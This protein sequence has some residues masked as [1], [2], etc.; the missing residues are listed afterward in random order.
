MLRWTLNTVQTQAS[1]LVCTCT[2][3]TFTEPYSGLPRTG[4]ADFPVARWSGGNHNLHRVNRRADSLLPL[5]GRS[6][7]HPFDIL[8]K[9]DADFT[10]VRIP[11][12]RA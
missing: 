8:Q 7:L 10:C 5:L 4:F 1:L 9:A 3:T 6:N 2:Q 12:I 11:D